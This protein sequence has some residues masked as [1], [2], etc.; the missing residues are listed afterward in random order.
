VAQLVA[1]RHRKPEVAGSNPAFPASGW[2]AQSGRA[3]V[4]YSEGRGFDPRP[5]LS[6]AISLSE[7]SGRLLPGR[8][9]VQALPDP[10]IDRPVAQGIR[11]AVS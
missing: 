5:N 3:S 2:V 9:G 8:L 10:Q 4:S 7:H 1:R 6:R 11:A